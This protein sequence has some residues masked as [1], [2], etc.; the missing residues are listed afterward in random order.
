M[1]EES[2]LKYGKKEEGEKTEDQG[3]APAV[4]N[5]YP[6]GIFLYL[7]ASPP[8]NSKYTHIAQSH[9]KQSRERQTSMPGG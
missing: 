1:P 3:Q 7:P 6:P 9:S 8:N 5:S 4:K 2:M